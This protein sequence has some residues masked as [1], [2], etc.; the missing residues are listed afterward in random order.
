MVLQNPPII[1]THPVLVIAGATGM[2]EERFK[3]L[4][5][6]PGKHSID[7]IQRTSIFGTSQII[8]KVLQSET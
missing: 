1:Y 4:E 5:A 3:K 8:R 6:I 7:L 2:L